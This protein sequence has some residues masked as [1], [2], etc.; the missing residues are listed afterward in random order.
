MENSIH[1]FLEN[2][3]PELE[4]IRIVFMKSPSLFDECAEEIKKVFLKAA[5]QFLSELLEEGNTLLEESLKRRMSWQIKDRCTRRILTP[6]GTVAFTHTRFK[7]K[8]TGETA[9]LLDRTVGWRAHTRVS[10]G[11]K[12]AMLEGAAQGSYERAGKSACE[13]EDCVGKETVMRCV[14]GTKAPDK[15]G[16]EKGEKREAGYLYVEADEDHAALQFHEKKGDIKR[17]KGHA[18]NGQMVKLVYVHEGYDEA[19]KEGERKKLKNVAYFGGI[20]EGKGNAALWEAVKG[21]IEREYRT[22]KIEKIFFQSDG[23]SWM[24]KGVDVLGAEFVLDEFHLSEYMGRMARLCGDTQEESDKMLTALRGWI[25]KGDRKRVEGWVE[26]RKAGLG[27]K[28]Q[29]KL[30]ADWR[31][32]KNNWKGIRRRIEG[33]DGMIGSSTEGH[34]SHVLSSRMSSRPMGWSREGADH[35]S[36]LRIYWMNG[37]D[38]LELVRVGKEKA[39]E[40]SEAV[41]LSAAE[42]L[43]WERKHKRTNGKYIE[44]LRAKVSRQTSVKVYFNAAIAGVC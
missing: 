33:E 15:S 32:L 34:V 10:D 16:G 17:Y 25:E 43:S 5:C 13:G 24:K 20:Y 40:A 30:E 26:E 36:R 19:G 12:A 31:Y 3:I 18:D 11:V 14:H 2:G 21:Y 38:M 9:Y 27:E 6:V 29:K 35:L 39:E 8:K 23:G 37:G 42:L 7:N 4:K 44:A 1:Y 28:G 22:E 41:C